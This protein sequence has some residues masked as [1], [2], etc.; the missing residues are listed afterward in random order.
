VINNPLP[1]IKA[2]PV[3]MS[4]LFSNL[5]SNALK[6]SKKDEP[7]I[8]TINVSSL[9]D[10]GL[11]NPDLKS[12]M[13]FLKIDFTDNGIGFQQE[14]AVQIFNIFQRLHGRSE[15]EGTGIGLAMCKKIMENHEGYIYANSKTGKGSTFTLI[16]PKE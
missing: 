15:Y 16:F 7:L 3:Q 14:N 10:P 1:V 8:I 6:F 2:V 11:S 9:N 12:G 5:V 4:Q 13:H